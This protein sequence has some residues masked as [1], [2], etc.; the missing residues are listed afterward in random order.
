MVNKEKRGKKKLILKSFNNIIAASEFIIVRF[1]D[2]TK[3]E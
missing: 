2:L 1:L 3:Q